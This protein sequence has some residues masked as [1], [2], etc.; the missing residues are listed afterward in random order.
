MGMKDEVVKSYKMLKEAGF[1][2]EDIIFEG[3]MSV[4]AKDILDRIERLSNER[5]AFG[6]IRIV[7]SVDKNQTRNIVIPVGK[8]MPEVEE[9]EEDIGL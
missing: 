2:V 3:A 5:S 7:Y 9:A 4:K 8:A 1:K 6:N